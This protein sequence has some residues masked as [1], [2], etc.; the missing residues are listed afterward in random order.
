VGIPLNEPERARRSIMHFSSIL[1][2]AI[3][4][5]A[6]LPAQ[7]QVMLGTVELNPATQNS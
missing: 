5:A 3:A 4:A 2:A 7:T 1:A 6:I